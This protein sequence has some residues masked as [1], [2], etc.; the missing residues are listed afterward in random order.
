MTRGALVFQLFVLI[1]L[2]RDAQQEVVGMFHYALK[3]NGR[4]LLGTAENIEAGDLFAVEEKGVALF[5]RRAV[6]TREPRFPLFSGVPRRPRDPE[7]NPATAATVA[8]YGALHALAT[9]Q[10]A[11]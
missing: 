1:Y 7:A 2:Q 11:R 3:E 6:P 4:L 8:S 9:A 10:A 5:R